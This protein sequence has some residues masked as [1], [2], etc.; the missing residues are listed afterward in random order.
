MKR[1]PQSRHHP[2]HPRSTLHASGIFSAA[3]HQT[4]HANAQV[5]ASAHCQRI[6]MHR[7]LPFTSAQRTIVR[8]AS[9]QKSRKMLLPSA[10]P[11]LKVLR[12]A[13]T[14]LSAAAVSAALLTTGGEGTHT[15]SRVA[16]SC[17]CLD[18]P[19]SPLQSAHRVAL[20]V[21]MHARRMRRVRMP[22]T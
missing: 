15:I 5:G 9:Q 1:P 21:C 16:S 20:S 19:I 17:R 10:G 8:C 12:S 18:F 22:S 2:P 3:M 13:G 14:M 7:Q 11:L 6:R 4:S